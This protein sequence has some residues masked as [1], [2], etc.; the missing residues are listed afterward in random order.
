MYCPFRVKQTFSPLQASKLIS[1]GHGFREAV[2]YYLPKLLLGPIWHAFSYFDYV[3]HLL[4]LSPSKEDREI[5]V[6]VQGLLGPLESSLKEIVVRLPNAAYARLNSRARRKLSIEKT[7]ELQSAVENWSDKESYNEFLREDTLQKLGSGKRI[8]ERKVYLFDGLLVLCK[9]NTRRQAVSVGATTYDFR[10][11]ERYYMRRDGV[12]D[13]NDSDDLKNGFEISP[14]HM[15][16]QPVVLIAKSGQHKNDWMADLIMINTKSML[17]RILDSILL[18]IEK[19]HPLRLPCPEIYKFAVP[20]SENNIVLED[21]ESTGVPLIKGAT[22]CKLIE[23]LTYHI[24]ADP[25]FLRIFLTTYRSFCTPQELLQ[26]LIERYD[27]PDP[28]VVYDQTTQNDK[29]LETEKLHKNSQREDWKRYRKEYVQPVQ[30]RVLNVLRHWVDHHFYDFERNPTLLEKLL[31]FLET[32]NGKSMRKWVESVLKIVQRK[33][34]QEENHKQITFAFGHSP[35][36][37]EYHLQVPEKEITLLTLHP[38]ELARQLTLLEFELYKNVKPSELV[39]S[40]WTKRDK[41][42]TSPNTLKISSHTTNFTLWLEHQILEAENFD[43]RVAMLTRAI[44]V[45]I[46]LL[47]LNNFH[48]A[49]ACVKSALDS[50]CIFRLKHTYKSIS[51]RHRQYFD[52]CGELTKDHW[53]LYLEKLRSINPPCVPFFGWYLTNILHIE[54][55]NPDFLP[56]PEL[57]NFSKRRKVA[58]ITGE[59]Q[60]YQNQPYC[61]K[62]D[63]KIRV[64]EETIT[65]NQFT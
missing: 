39:G 5:F 51:D 61:L 19:K 12:V 23:R 43:E 64:S 24:Y 35:P 38:L 56:N 47:D 49:I 4:E 9:A 60:Q 46:A 14:R 17:D 13:R 50:A 45:M 32:V 16:S 1:A 11:K 30:I 36:A 33:Q 29:D 52:D 3:R 22:I 54:E 20:D 40:V 34:E 25:A 8:T 53:K 26:L 27:I 6:Q 58:E 63:P 48:G 59:I 18:D 28:A 41:E 57:I 2:K 42:T 10:L 37:I 55:G 7:R 15:P 44:E 65:G 21:R 62:V 31:E